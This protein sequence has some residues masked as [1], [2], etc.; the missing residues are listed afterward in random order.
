MIYSL[1]MIYL[2]LAS[3]L[4]LR[5]SSC[6]ARHQ[7]LCCSPTLRR[8]PTLASYALLFSLMHQAVWIYREQASPCLACPGCGLW[9]LPALDA[10][11]LQQSCPLQLLFFSHLFRCWWGWPALQDLHV[12]KTNILSMGRIR[13]SETVLCQTVALV[14]ILGLSIRSNVWFE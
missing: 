9:K 10:P 12:P 13:L 5:R 7:S 3:L 1:D 4:W 8:G 14:L 6:Q 11:F 2:N